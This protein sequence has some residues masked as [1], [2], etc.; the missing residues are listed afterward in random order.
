[1]EEPAAPY[2]VEIEVLRGLAIIM[3]VIGNLPDNLLFWRSGLGDFTHA[4]WNGEAGVDLFFAISGF[5]VA[6][7]LLPRLQRSEGGQDRLGILLTFLLRRF[8]RLQPAAWLW[9]LGPLCVGAVF[10]RSGAFHTLHANLAA[11]LAACL[12]FANFHLAAIFGHGDGGLSFPDWTLSLQEQFSILLP[13]LAVLF[14]ARLAWAM[15][16]LLAWQL[17]MPADPLCYATRPGALA[18]GVLVA[19]CFR[20]PAARLAEPVFLA[21]H[22]AWRAITLAAV[23]V[24]LGALE[25]DLPRPLMALPYLLAA[26]LSALLVYAAGFDRFYIMPPSPA[27]DLLVWIGNRSYA[28]YLVHVPAFALTRE[29]YMRLQPPGLFHST[30]EATHDIVVALFLTLGLGEVTYRL[31]ERPLRRRGGKEGLLF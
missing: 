9:V 25:S 21:R 5:V 31:V 22:P 30:Q 16:A 15:L 3:V 6:R 26:L 4:Y 11:G 19:L 24:C 13:L 12:G 27:R 23:I 20:S 28:I 18:A 1:M 17:V 2:L 10:N 29:L 14:R 7:G 8:W